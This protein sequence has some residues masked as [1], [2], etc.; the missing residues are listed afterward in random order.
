MKKPAAGGKFSGWGILA[1]IPFLFRGNRKQG[2]VLEIPLILWGRKWAR[3][4]R[5]WTVRNQRTRILRIQAR[6]RTA[7]HDFPGRTWDSVRSCWKKTNILWWTKSQKLQSNVDCNCSSATNDFTAERVCTMKRN[8]AAKDTDPHKLYDFF[9]YQIKIA[10]DTPDSRECRLKKWEF[11]FQ[12]VVWS[13]ESCLSVANATSRIDDGNH[14]VLIATSGELC[15]SRTWQGCWRSGAVKN[16]RIFSTYQLPCWALSEQP[17]I[18]CKFQSHLITQKS[19]VQ[20]S[21]LFHGSCIRIKVEWV[22]ELVVAAFGCQNCWWRNLV[23]RAKN[24]EELAKKTCQK[25]ERYALR[26]VWQ[27]GVY[28][29]GVRG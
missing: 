26:K 8:F 9:R 10:S 13:D 7:L 14:D 28:I 15:R 24:S 22:T 18:S 17:I 16:R 12:P 11:G 20:E 6:P 5:S 4:C 21:A 29:L 25:Y 1:K 3:S 19:V 2:V 27:I 23:Q